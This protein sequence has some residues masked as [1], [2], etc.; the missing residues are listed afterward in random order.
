[1][2]KKDRKSNEEKEQEKLAVE[3]VKS[4]DR[5]RKELD[6]YYFLMYSM[7]KYIFLFIGCALMMLPVL[8]GDLIV[9]CVSA[10][11]L[12]M[13]ADFHLS[14]YQR[15]K[16][17]GKIIGIYEKCKRLPVSRKDIRKVRREY[18]FQF[19][20]KIG[21]AALLSQLFGAAL[22]GKVSFWNVLYPV[23][24]WLLVLGVGNLDIFFETK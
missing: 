16:E 10:F 7:E 17:N 12:S 14:P 9:Y 3:Q 15:V 19:S 20:V 18:L 23:A 24:V 1:M 2:K 22:A 21:I 4:F 13:S 6:S 5:M 11:L 8:E